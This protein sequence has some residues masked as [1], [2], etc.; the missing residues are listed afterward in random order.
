MLVYYSKLILA[1][2]TMS[3][4]TKPKIRGNLYNITLTALK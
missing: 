1:I 3:F 4:A 2:K